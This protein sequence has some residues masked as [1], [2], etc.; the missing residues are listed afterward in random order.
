MIMKTVLAALV[1][2]STLA[3][4]VPANAGFGPKDLPIQDTAP[5]FGPK[6]LPIQDTA[7]GF[8]PKDLPEPVGPA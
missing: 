6:D 7:P 8:G 5:G 2:L 3:A 1:A 4:I